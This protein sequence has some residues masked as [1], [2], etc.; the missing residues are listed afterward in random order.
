MVYKFGGLGLR[1]L[2]E[3]QIWLQGTRLV[4]WPYG[5][6]LKESQIRVW[7]TVY[8]NLNDVYCF[9]VGSPYYNYV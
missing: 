9:S 5:K 4:C 8:G 7:V 6:K 3:A 2:G 1:G